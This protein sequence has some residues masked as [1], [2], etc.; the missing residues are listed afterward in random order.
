MP[1]A[2]RAAH[3]RRRNSHALFIIW[4]TW[5]KGFS[6]CTIAHNTAGTD[7]YIKAQY[8]AFDRS[9]ARD[10]AKIPEAPYRVAMPSG[11]TREAWRFPLI[12]WY[13]MNPI[14]ISAAIIG[15]I[16]KYP[17]SVRMRDS[18]PLMSPIWLPNIPNQSAIHNDKGNSA[19][20]GV[21][22]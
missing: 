8:Q 11:L 21:F 3:I 10:V 17:R 19:Q 2:K 18:F 12:N 4:V 9:G 15:A 6:T 22:R 1:T 16:L 20:A 14:A 7:K 5:S 13:D